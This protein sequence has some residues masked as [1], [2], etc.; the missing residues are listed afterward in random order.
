[1]KIKKYKIKDLI[2]AEYNPRKLTPIKEQDLRNSLE[3]FGMVDPVIINTNEKRKNIII[4]GHQRIKIWE[5]FGHKEVDCTELN[6]S[7]KD[8]K[9]LNIR[10]NK[11]TGDWDYQVLKN[12]EY[13]DPEDLVIYGFEVNEVYNSI[14]DSVEGDEIEIEIP[15]QQSLQ[16]IPKQEYI[17]VTCNRDSEEWTELQTI[18]KLKRVRNGGARQGS[19]ADSVSTERVFNLQEFKKRINDYSNS[20]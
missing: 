4:G 18:M 15:I 1:M 10:L 7:A 14:E 8:E 17:I 5:S 19:S 6:L 2:K 20:K 11:N 16:V 12:S 3:K 9:E 13:F